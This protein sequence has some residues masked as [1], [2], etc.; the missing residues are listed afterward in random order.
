MALASAGAGFPSVSSWS[1]VTAADLAGLTNPGTATSTTWPS[2][3]LALFVP[4]PVL[5]RPRTMVKAW[6]INGTVA[7]GNV[8]VGIYT[9]SGTTA[10]RVVASTAEAQGTVST[11]QVAAAFTST[12]LQ[13]GVQ[14]YGAMSCSLGT[15]TVWRTLAVNPLVRAL[16][17]YQAATSHPLPSTAT[18][19]AVANQVLPA[20]GFSEVAAI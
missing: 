4:L 18:V 7:A 15:A 12:T 20:F 19:V 10:T 9:I 13:P 3:A 1:T 16:G 5:A 17:C 6:W 2:A 8:D 14:Y 11:L